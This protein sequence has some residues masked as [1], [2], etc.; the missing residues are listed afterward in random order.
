MALK[1]PQP[2]GKIR[3]KLLCTQFDK[4]KWNNQHEK[5]LAQY[6]ALNKSKKTTVQN[7]ILNGVVKHI[8][9]AL[10][11]Y[12][13]LKLLEGTVALAIPGAGIMIAIYK[14]WKMVD[15]KITDTKKK[16]NQFNVQICV[17]GVGIADIGGVALCLEI[18]FVSSTFAKIVKACG[19]VKTW[20]KD[21]KDKIAA[22]WSRKFSNKKKPKERADGEYDI[23]EDVVAVLESNQE[24][25]EE[26]KVAD[27]FEFTNAYNELLDISDMF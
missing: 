25:K 17:E 19:K 10:L 9:K 20:F 4:S 24:I 22:W 14:I 1:F 16:K 8:L 11:K 6:N 2:D 23:G 15:V 5:I 21:K 18:E 3:P 13:L 27:L 7:A 12:V 26:N